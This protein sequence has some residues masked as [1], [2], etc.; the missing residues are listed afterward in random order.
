MSRIQVSDI[1]SLIYNLEKRLR[2]MD[3]AM[4]S[5]KFSEALLITNN[6]PLL[7][8][9]NVE[10]GLDR[11]C[12][13]LCKIDRGGVGELGVIAVPDPRERYRM[14]RKMPD[15]I[16]CFAN[17]FHTKIIVFISYTLEINCFICSDLI[18]KISQLES[19]ARRLP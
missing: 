1:F 8:K 14:G 4:S 6:H 11:F 13:R 2:K 17:K 9:N 12:P 19:N 18:L 15:F 10:V 5:F 16:T 3:V 7:P